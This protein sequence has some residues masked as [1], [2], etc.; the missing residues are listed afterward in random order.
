MARFD[1]EAA[2]RQG[3]FDFNLSFATDARAVV[4]F[5]PSGSGK[6]TA[7]ELVAGLRPLERGRIAVNGHVLADREA[8]VHAPPR[9]RHVGYVPQ[10]VLLFPHLDVRA[11]VRYGQRTGARPDER[12]LIDLL[13]LEPLMARSVTTLSGGERQRVAIARALYSAPEVLLLDE[14]LAAVDLPRRSRIVESL[15]RVRDE[16]HVPL[17]YVTHA[18]DEARLVAE[19]AVVLEGGRKVAEG[20]PEEVL[21]G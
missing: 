16:L 21:P 6:T 11:N 10:D 2:L 17:I 4:L 20:K 3:S 1:F 12:A 8:G 14:P 15:L 9:A 13:E 19:F 18:P 7:L 5:G